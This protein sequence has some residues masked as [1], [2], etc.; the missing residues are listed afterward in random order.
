MH[1]TPVLPR[2][3]ALFAPSSTLYATGVSALHPPAQTNNQ[4]IQNPLG[5]PI[6]I[7]IRQAA[8]ADLK[9]HTNAL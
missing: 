2:L 4:K 9:H 1:C 8:Q 6:A 3:S 7:Q 5:T